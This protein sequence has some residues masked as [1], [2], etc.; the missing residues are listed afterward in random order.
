MYP[1]LSMSQI[2]RVGRLRRLPGGQHAVDTPRGFVA[3]RQE[4]LERHRSTGD[5]PEFAE[6]ERR[7]IPVAEAVWRPVPD[8]GAGM[9]ELGFRPSPAQVASAILSVAVHRLGPDL[10]RDARRALKASRSLR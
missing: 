3:V 5:R 4:L 10:K 2:G 7:K 6:A 9:A 8:A 1:R